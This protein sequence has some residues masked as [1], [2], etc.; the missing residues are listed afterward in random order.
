[1][2]VGLE[3]HPE[4]GGSHCGAGSGQRTMY[5]SLNH[6]LGLYQGQTASISRSTD[7]PDLAVL[8]FLL[9][10]LTAETTQVPY[11]LGSLRTPLIG[12]GNDMYAFITT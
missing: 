9:P 7:S 8:S 5:L 11:S 12:A 10:T 6:R 1:M 4:V 2:S 3:A